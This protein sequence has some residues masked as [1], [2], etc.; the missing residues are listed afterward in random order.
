M[1]AQVA[2]LMQDSLRLCK[3]NI[4]AIY[5]YNLGFPAETVVRIFRLGTDMTF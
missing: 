2:Q 1:A 3:F 5:F 4:S